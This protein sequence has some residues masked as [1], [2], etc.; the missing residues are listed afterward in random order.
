MTRTSWLLFNFLLFFFITLIALALQTTLLHQVFGNNGTIQIVLVIMTYICITRRP[1]EALLFT[2]LCC[3]SI[4]LLSTILAGA[5]VFS[6]F[7]I[8]LILRFFRALVYTPSHVYFNWAALGAV[9]GFHIIGWI[10]GWFFDP[11]PPSFLFIPWVLE[12][13]LTALF[14]KLILNMCLWID[15]RTHRAIP[16]EIPA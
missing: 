4:S 10:L 14:C 7:S 8:F 5:A 3:Y 12:V 1:I 16:T 9:F 6:G 2:F 11:S 13:L 15:S